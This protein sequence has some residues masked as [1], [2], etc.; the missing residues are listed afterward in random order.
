MADP[1]AWTGIARHG[2]LSTQALLDLYEVPEPLRGRLLGE[3]RPD[4]VAVSHPVH[5]TA[6]VRDQKP[7]HPA[8]LAACLQDGVTVEQWLR[9][10]NSRVFFWLQPER[11]E[12]LLA[13]RAYRGRDHLVL[14]VDTA[15]L[16]DAVPDR[17]V[18]LSRINSG[19]TVFRAVPRGAST[20]LPVEDFP[21]PP[22][23]RALASAT[24]VAELCVSPG[25][26]DVLAVA[27][28]AELRGPSGRRTVWER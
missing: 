27:D 25:V 2:L 13:A 10:L 1:G 28:R 22:R 6:V 18:T 5:G 11:L 23:R 12:R 4:S 26:P 24:D 19:A 15:R 17:A 3:H 21:H 8:K 7:L 9:L 14:T 16:L 20:F